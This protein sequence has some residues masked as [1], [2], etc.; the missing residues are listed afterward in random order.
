MNGGNIVKVKKFSTFS[1]S[2]G[3]EKALEL[4]LDNN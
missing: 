4:E 3:L 2:K 1:I